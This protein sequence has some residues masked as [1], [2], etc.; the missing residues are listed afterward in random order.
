MRAII[1]ADI[2]R[3]EVGYGAEQGWRAI[4]EDPEAIPPFDYVRDMLNQRIGYI[5][6]ATGS[7]NCTLYLT[8]GP[9]FRYDIATKKPYKGNRQDKKPW[10]FD[11]LTVY[12]RDVLR[13]TVCTGIEADD[14]MAID[15]YQAEANAE[16]TTLCSRDKDLRQVRGRFYSWE[17]GK[18]PSFGPAQVGV[19]G[20]LEIKTDKK[21]PKVT[22]TGYLW[23]C[24]QVLM[25]DSVDNI[26]GLPGVGPVAAYNVL[27]AVADLEYSTAEDNLVALEAV[28]EREY[29]RVYGDDWEKELTEQAQLCWIVRRLNEDG[30]PEVW[31]KGLYS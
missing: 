4:K 24:A 7:D 11:N 31:R 10:H 5:R 1:D 15:Q 6:G 17:L 30:T 2:L 20:T 26:P 3:Y 8:E 22:G 21:P 29:Q 19:V 14:A 16:D 12:L 13:A 27:A 28:L 18:Q 25:G 9:T 23:F